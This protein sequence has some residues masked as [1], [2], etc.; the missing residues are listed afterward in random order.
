VEGVEHHVDGAPQSLLM[1]QPPADDTLGNAFIL[2]YT[3]G[4]EI[5]DKDDKKLWMFDKRA[6]G[7]GQY[8]RVRPGRC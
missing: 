5:F 6:Y 7:G 4:P 3:W 8:M 1:A 2:H